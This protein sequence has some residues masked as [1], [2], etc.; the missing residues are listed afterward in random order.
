MGAVVLVNV[1]IMIIEANNT[2]NCTGD[3]SDSTCDDHW[4]DFANLAFLIVYMIELSTRVYVQRW[5]FRKNSWNL[6]D[7][8]VVITGTIDVIVT[9]VGVNAKGYGLAY[10]RLFR[11]ARI[12]RTIRLFRAFPELFQLVKGFAVTMKAIFW[13]TVMILCVLTMWALVIVQYVQSFAGPLLAEH[14][15]EC[16]DHYSS[17][18]QCIVLLFQTVIAGDNWG[19]CT[20]PI[21]VRRPDAF[22]VFSAAF[23]TVQI[24]FLNLILAVIV[25]SSMSSREEDSIAKLNAKKRA[26]VE[27]L[28]RFYKLMEQVDVNNNGLVSQ[29]ELLEGYDL[30]PNV[31]AMFNDLNIDRADL[32]M[33]FEYLVKEED[34][35]LSYAELVE[36]LRRASEQETKVQL[37]VMKLQMDKMNFLVSSI[38]KSMSDTQATAKAASARNSGMSRFINSQPSK[39]TDDGHGLHEQH[40]Q[41]NVDPSFNVSAMQGFHSQS[42]SKQTAHSLVSSD[43]SSEDMKEHYTVQWNVKSAYQAP[44]IIRPT[45]RPDTFAAPPG[46]ADKV[47]VVALASLEADLAKFRD[48][49]DRHFLKL[50]ATTRETTLSLE[51]NGNPSGGSAT[52]EL[53]TPPENEATARDP[54]AICIK[55]ALD[56]VHSAKQKEVYSIDVNIATV[57][58]F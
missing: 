49:T 24:G 50:L 55:S 42:E 17:V 8:A 38:A 2:G 3:S 56:Q 30:D 20:V 1:I 44:E 13:G 7:A 35:D 9:F 32:E 28:K 15:P 34:D 41:S 26:E 45:P 12:L 4:T 23:V 10:I 5:E 37:M 16:I 29:E 27:N 48:D 11:I 57:S 43:T 47:L 25:D 19:S 40:H 54:S 52:L 39:L 22:F 14:A 6:L 31:Q 53:E 36:A 58:P 46:M 21:I 33:I 18:Q 51:P